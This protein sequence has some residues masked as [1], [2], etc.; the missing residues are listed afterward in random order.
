MP[1]VGIQ[2]PDLDKHLEKVYNQTEFEEICFDY[3]LELDDVTSEKQSA[4]KEKGNVS[5]EKLSDV[6]VYKVDI[7]ANRYDLLCVEGL[8]RAI[9]IF[10]ERMPQPDYKLEKPADG[11]LERIIVKPQTKGVRPFVV[12]AILRD[13]TLDERSYAS[14]ID[15]QDKLH[16]NICRK[17]SLVA[18][19]TH[20][21]DTVKGPF[22]YNAEKPSEFKFIPLNE[23]NEFNAEQLMVHY[24]GDSHLKP[25]LPILAGQSHYPVIRDASGIV[26]SM[27]PI[28][29]GDHSKITLKTRNI[30]IEATATDLQ[31]AIVVLDTMV[32][33][34]SQYCNKPFTVE[35][36]EVHYEE[37]G[38]VETYPKLSYREKD[39]EVSEVNTKMGFDLK[40][41]EMAT[42]LT[43]MSLGAKLLDDHTL[44]VNIPPTRHDILHECDIAEDVGVAYG[45]N[46]LELRLP[47][48]HTVAT[49][50]P[51]NSLSDHLRVHLACA[52]FTEALN[53]A[54]CSKDDSSTRLRRPLDNAVLIANPKTLEFQMART[55]L[56]PGLLRT[57]QANSHMPLPLKLFE[58]Q[59]VILADPNHEVGARNE[60]RVG[61]IVYAK[62]AGFESVHG[63]LDRLMTLLDVR[64]KKDGS[65]YHIEAEDDPAFLPGRCASIIAPGGKKIGKLGCLHPEVITA[66]SL[67]LP[68]A[69]IEFTIEPFV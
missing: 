23:T 17:R 59:D 63:V 57:V 62:Q 55:S 34:Y 65:G 66:F 42:L 36:V 4:E 44:R 35:P 21:L 3:G 50:L 19:G 14:F 32:T 10:Q 13:V 39:V 54:L 41:E 47:Q 6:E 28:I 33:M 31:K 40:G 67:S 37:D 64:M 53:F 24:S 61:A 22:V 20:D 18:I 8:S 49:P 52:G 48:A 2:K 25:Y 43:K 56:L 27:P 38:R 16:Q 7:P 46:K 29:N 58:L 5:G 51:L 11:E 26:C 45:F 9:K 69:A 12:G 30:F 1:T 60:R 15:L 68:T